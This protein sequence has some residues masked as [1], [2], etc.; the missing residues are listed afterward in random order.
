MA[1]SSTRD[2]TQ[3]SPLKLLLGF[4]FPLLGGFLFQQLY[5]FVDTYIVGAYLG[6]D[7]L[8]AVGST[9]S[10]NFLINGFCMGICSG[11]SIPVA[12][13]FGAKDESEMR[14]FVMHAVYLCAIIAVAMALVTGF[15]TPQLLDMLG[16]RSDLR[17]DAISYIQPVFFAIPFTV[18]YNMAAGVMRSLG[19][20]RTP[21]I[22]IVIAALTNIALDLLFIVG[23]KMG[24]A[25][26][27]YATVISQLLSGLWCLFVIRRKFTILRMQK[28]DLTWRKPFVRRLLSMGIPFGLQYSITAVGSLTVT[29]AVNGIS[30]EAVSAVTAAGKLSML[31]CI[32]FD[33][34]AS[35]MATFAGQNVGARK[36]DRIH[37]GLKAA[38]I[39]GC[40]YCVAAFVLIL[41]CGRQ[42]VSLFVSA[43]DPEIVSR[44][45]DYAHQFLIVN[46]ALY[47]PLL[48][49]NIVRFTIQ[50]VGFTTVA[51]TAGAMELIG[52]AGVALLLVPFFG[53]DAAVWANP[54][55]WLLADAFLFPC[56][57]TVMKWLRNRLAL[58]GQ[59]TQSP[60]EFMAAKKAAE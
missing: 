43:D 39:V 53:F 27:A 45:L 9:G 30:T 60:K 40:I 2:L 54:A 46:S 32:V 8:A 50:G 47:I 7:K 18:L 48:F 31:F 17:A 57:F 37:Q 25:G 21:M 20:G 23:L 11:F 22:A 51:M 49:V 59:A 24:V 44:V 58:T 13:A 4:A 38:S 26:A 3:G 15:L 12:Q 19:D 34:L 5:S 33:A 41:F 1:R 6:Y 52:R 35:A 42:M 55:A 10:L 36:L 14:R 28:D 56:Y 16:T 29:A